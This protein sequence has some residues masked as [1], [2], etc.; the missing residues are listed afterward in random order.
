MVSREICR[1]VVIV[2]GCKTMLRRTLATST[3]IIVH[4]GSYRGGETYTEEYD[5]K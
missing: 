4:S 1:R 2:L 5:H 3:R